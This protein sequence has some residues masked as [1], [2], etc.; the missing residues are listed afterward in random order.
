MGSYVICTDTHLDGTGWQ[1]KPGGPLAAAR[2]FVLQ[3]QGFE[4][5]RSL[6]RYFISANISGYL[7]RV[8]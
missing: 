7:K 1:E 8:R 4:I 3:N 5:D 6:D 2:E